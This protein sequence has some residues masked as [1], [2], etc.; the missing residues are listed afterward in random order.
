MTKYIVITSIFEPTEAVKAF[1]QNPNF[2][3]IVIGD[4]KSPEG[5]ACDNVDYFSVTRQNTLGFNLA[6]K[7]PVNHYCRKMIGYLVAMSNGE[8]IIDTDDDNI[9]KE[10][11]GFLNLLQGGYPSLT[12]EGFVNI[13]QWYTEQK[14]WPRGL[15]LNMIQREFNNAYGENISASS[16]G[17]WQGLADEDPD[18]DAV[19]RLTKNT[20][21]Y[22]NEGSPLVL[23]K[24]L[25]SPFNSQNTMF[26]KDVFLL[27]YLP[28]SVTFRFT[29]ILRGFVAQPIM[30][31]HDFHLG[32]IGPTV[33]QKRNEHNLMADFL[34]EI[35]MY[36][37]CENVLNW[38]SSS[39][40]K[41]ESMENNL[42]NAYDKLLTHKVVKSSEMIALEAWISD[43]QALL[44]SRK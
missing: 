38:I 34:S 32:F 2:K 29:D 20:P 39:I 15:P 4:R 44:S 41:N 43:V 9:P 11:W 26:T 17:V 30:W 3:L 27:M 28:I 8:L 18:V 6:N 13:Y 23:Q 1:S 31:A 40:S 19:Y 42:F 24:G 10:N 25:I 22:F 12:G 16:V 14:I 5:W 7:L 37:N 21:C 36:E 35:P 33:K